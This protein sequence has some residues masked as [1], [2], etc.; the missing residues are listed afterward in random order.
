MACCVYIMHGK[1]SGRFPDYTVFACKFKTDECFLFMKSFLVCKLETFK[2]CEEVKHIMIM[3]IAIIYIFY[4]MWYLINSWKLLSENPQVPTEKI[5]SLLFTHSPPPEN[6]KIA[7]AP[8]FTNIE[9]FLG[10]PIDKG[11]RRGHC[12]KLIIDY[13]LCFKFLY[14]K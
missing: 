13:W 2:N 14:F 8:L 1:F 4:L 7:S 3:I 12:D 9:N 6:S 5:H 11:G 10:L